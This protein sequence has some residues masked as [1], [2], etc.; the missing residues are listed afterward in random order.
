MLVGVGVGVGVVVDI[1]EH[2]LGVLEWHLL[3]LLLVAL[4]DDMLLALPMPRRHAITTCLLLLLLTELLR[5]LLDFPAH[6]RAVVPRVLYRAPRTALITIG[7]LSLPLVTTWATAPIGRYSSGSTSQ[8]LVI[9]AGLL[10][11]V[12]EQWHLHRACQ[13]SLPLG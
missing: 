3:I 8:R 10:L 7:G 12:F 4:L 13:L 6:L 5:E 2:L 1:L 11:F 9:V